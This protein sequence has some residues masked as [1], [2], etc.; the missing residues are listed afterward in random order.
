[1]AADWEVLAAAAERSP[2]SLI[3]VPGL[4]FSLV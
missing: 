4:E 1:M 2:G 3:I